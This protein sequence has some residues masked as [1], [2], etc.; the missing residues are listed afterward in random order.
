[1]PIR[2]RVVPRMLRIVLSIRKTLNTGIRNKLIVPILYYGVCSDPVYTG[3]NSVCVHL[4]LTMKREHSNL[5]RSR[6]H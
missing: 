4:K 3:L 6:K 1:M 2:A 5:L